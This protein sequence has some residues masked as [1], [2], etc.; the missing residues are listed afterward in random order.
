MIDEIAAFLKDVPPFQFLSEDELNNVALGVE[1]VYYPKEATILREDGPPSTQLMV[2]RSGGVKVSVGAGEEEIVLDYRAE[3]DLI[4]F[5]S[6]VSADRSRA[7][8]AAIEETTV[9]Q[10]ERER[11]LPLLESNPAFREYYLQS[12]LPK[13]IDK[14]FA[15]LGERGT[16]YTGGDKL[17]FTTPV[18]ELGAREV[19]TAGAAATVREAAALMSARN[20]SSLVLLDAGGAPVGI[21]TDRD[22]REK[23]VAAGRDGSE[24]VAGIMSPLRFTIDARSLAFE[25]LLTM[26]RHDIHHLVVLEEGRLRGIVTNHDLMLLQGTSPLSLTR[27]IEAQQSVEGLVSASAK[28]SGM[29]TFLLKEGARASNITRMVTEINDRLVMKI[30]QFAERALGPPPLS[31]CWIV[32][33][34]EGR[35]EQTFKTDQDNA[36]IHEDPRTP[37]EQ[38]AAGEY[39]GRFAAYV[40][41][42]LVRCGFPKCPGNYMASNP[43][44]CQPLSAWRGYFSSWIDEPTEEAILRSVILFDFR[45]VAGNLALGAL[46]K[47]HLLR[48]VEGQ[49]I[50]LKKMADLAVSVRPPLGFFKTFVV[51]KSGEHKDQIDLKKKCITPLINVVRLYALQEGVPETSTLDRIHALSEGGTVVRELADELVRAYEFFLLLRIHH[52]YEQ[53]QSGGEPD[54]FINPKELSNLQK[55]VFRDSCQSI[56]A[57]LDAAFRQYNPGM[58]L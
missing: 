29:V 43:E 16:G 4:G 26:I 12:F 8:V 15:Q 33:G 46:L 14:V 24:G 52:Q 20:I 36:L 30:V 11:I 49:G 35:K 55:K 27:D 6:L 47:A 45:P 32:F 38:A 31:Y 51:L 41:E 3:G 37:E 22:L 25:A 19:V 50:F 57:A 34:S 9:Y 42:A 2:I 13:F 40:N 53:I 10:V 5:L 1:V 44:W 17:L 56:S 39:F 54:N 7:E 48:A 28:I 23:V 58:R 18:G 21:V